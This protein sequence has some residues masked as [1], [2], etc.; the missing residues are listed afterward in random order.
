[1]LPNVPVSKDHTDTATGNAGVLAKYPT[2]SHVM[3]EVIFFTNTF[4]FSV[5]FLILLKPIKPLAVHYWDPLKY[6]VYKSVL[7]GSPF[8]EAR[9]SIVICYTALK[10]TGLFSWANLYELE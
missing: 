5:P 1:V 8:S 6:P 2:T 4:P 9:R 3:S 10:D 7:L